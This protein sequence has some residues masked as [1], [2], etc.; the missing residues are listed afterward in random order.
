MLVPVRELLVGWTAIC[1]QEGVEGHEAKDEEEEDEH[2]H[3]D[4]DWRNHWRRAPFANEIVSCSGRVWFRVEDE[5]NRTGKGNHHVRR[6]RAQVPVEEAIV[7]TA[8]AIPQPGAVMV[9]V[10]DATVAHRAVW[11]PWWPIEFASCAPFHLNIDVPYHNSAIQWR[12]WRV[13]VIVSRPR[14]DAGVNGGGGA[15]VEEGEEKEEHI[16]QQRTVDSIWPAARTW[17]LE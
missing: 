15:K 6:Q 5:H 9:K 2:E 7:S 16:E 13:V 14:D 4:D 17:R 10:L 1:D 8:N 11:A 12:Q 3:A